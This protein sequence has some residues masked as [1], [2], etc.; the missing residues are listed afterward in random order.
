M[1]LFFVQ[2]LEAF[3]T[4]PTGLNL[5]SHVMRELNHVIDHVPI[6]DQETMEQNAWGL[7]MKPVHVPLKCAQH[8]VTAVKASHQI[9]L[10][11]L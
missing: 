6:Q 7:L 4:G 1:W 5:A 9:E 8:Q 11:E 10:I 2:L 3:Q